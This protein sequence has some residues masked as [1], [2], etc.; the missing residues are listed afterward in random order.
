M[1]NIIRNKSFIFYLL[2]YFAFSFEHII[3][4]NFFSF[5][6][7]TMSLIL[8]ILF[9]S[10]YRNIEVQSSKI[11]YFIDSMFLTLLILFFY[12]P[13]F[14]IP[15]KNWVNTKLEIYYFRNKEIILFYLLF[16]FLNIYIINKNEI[17]RSKINIF[18]IIYFIV[19]L[20]FIK[21]TSI[22]LSPI[23]DKIQKY[24]SSYN[25]ETKIILIILDEYASPSELIKFSKNKEIKDFSSFLKNKG[26]V[27]K[28]N[29]YTHE[30][31]TIRS[32]GSMFNFNISNDAYWKKNNSIELESN[33]LLKAKLA[34]SLSNKNVNI[35]NLGLFDF[36]KNPPQY[37][38][39]FYPKSFIESFLYMSSYKN[40]GIFNLDLL[41]FKE[42]NPIY[43]NNYHILSRLDD[44]LKSNNVNKRFI[45]SHLMMPHEPMY[46]KDEF[47]RRKI[48][49]L[50][51]YTDYW[52][53]T[54]K[55][56]RILLEN[57]MKMENTKIILSGDH[58][59]R[60]DKNINSK[61]TFSAFYGFDTTELKKINSVQDIGILLN[62]SFSK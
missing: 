35:I 21:L 51:N 48:Y 17:R 38:N 23:S 44:T 8:L 19:S 45:Y 61:I 42:N 15:T 49:D 9:D 11:K 2:P 40:F 50:K 20:F 16:I 7:L 18:F 28:T 4:S 37:R 13:I 3:N 33:L 32:I 29:F 34:D 41:N 39:F 25:K 22:N 10:I 58:G 14:I 54:N 62:N 47:D 30:T 43:K 46:Y 5:S 1:K 24:Q 55:K 12:G 57:I 53:F 60:N 27:V 36:G 52:I 26:F 31:K 56:L 6:S 59:Y